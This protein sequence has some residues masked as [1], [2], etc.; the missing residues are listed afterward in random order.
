M[1]NK[2]GTNWLLLRGLAREAEHWG[3]FRTTLQSEFPSAHIST[4]DLPGQVSITNKPAQ[5]QYRKLQ[6]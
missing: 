5:Q 6:T 4:I 1:H 2:I 3:E